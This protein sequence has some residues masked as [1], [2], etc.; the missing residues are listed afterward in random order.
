MS[1]HYQKEFRIRRRTM[2]RSHLG[3]SCVVCGSTENLEV[4][5]IDPS[6]KLFN[7]ANS[8]HKKWE[9]IVKEL[10][11][12]Q[13][14]CKPH[15]IEKTNSELLGRVPVN[16]GVITH[17]KQYPAYTLKCSCD[18]CK[19]YKRLRNQQRR[20]STPSNNIHKGDLNIVHGTRAGYLKEARLKLTHC[21]AC[22]QANSEYAKT[23]R[24]RIV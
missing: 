22:K 1:Y 16:K 21:E 15:H 12:C 20:S 4:D 11:K 14:L 5:H 6:T 7:I 10:E 24:G 13:L 18:D 2:I 23:F 17:G 9:E 19:E 8:L 3:G